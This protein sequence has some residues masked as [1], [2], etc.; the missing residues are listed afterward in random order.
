[1]ITERRPS[2]VGALDPHAPNNIP[3]GFCVGIVWG[4]LSKIY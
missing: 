3:L 2:Y 1:M 4:K